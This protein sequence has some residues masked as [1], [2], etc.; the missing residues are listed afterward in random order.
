MI[1]YRDYTR[2]FKNLVLRKIALK[3]G[4][5]LSNYLIGRLDGIYTVKFGKLGEQTY[6]SEIFNFRNSCTFPLMYHVYICLFNFC[7][8]DHLAQI[9]SQ[10]KEGTEI[11]YSSLVLANFAWKETIR[12]LNGSQAVFFY[13]IPPIESVIYIFLQSICLQYNNSEISYVLNLP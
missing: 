8:H 6:V 13:I 4:C 7:K 3:F 2:I 12:S 10:I 11:D 1:H 9:K 5:I